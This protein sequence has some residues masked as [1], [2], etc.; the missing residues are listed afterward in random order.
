[1]PLVGFTCVRLFRVV[2]SDLW[3]LLAFCGIFPDTYLAAPPLP[4]LAAGS[5]LAMT[6]VDRGTMAV[7]SS[8]SVM[9]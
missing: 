5:L 6:V 3:K 1:M 7:S 2:A 9:D 4:G 8:Y